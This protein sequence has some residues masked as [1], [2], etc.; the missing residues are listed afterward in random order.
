MTTIRTETDSFGKVELKQRFS[1]CD[2]LVKNI[3]VVPF[4]VEQVLA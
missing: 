4:L 1:V 3:A 2:E